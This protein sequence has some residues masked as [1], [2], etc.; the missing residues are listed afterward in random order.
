MFMHVCMHVFMY[1]WSPHDL[2]STTSTDKL[3]WSTC[4]SGSALDFHLDCLSCWLSSVSFLAWF[5]PAWTRPI[6][7]LLPSVP[8]TIRL[9]NPVSACVWIKRWFYSAVVSHLSPDPKLWQQPC[10]PLVVEDGCI[11][12]P[13]TESN[14]I[15]WSCFGYIGW[16]FQ[17]YVRNK[18]IQHSLNNTLLGLD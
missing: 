3:R 7:V 11:G 17:C 9:P 15:F 6:T 14:R 4:A 1:V 10:F 12:W 2:T 5:H 8:P 18:Q 13:K 16:V